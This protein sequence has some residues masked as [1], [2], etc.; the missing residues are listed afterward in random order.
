MKNI[1]GQNNCFF[2]P[3]NSRPSNVSGDYTQLPDPWSQFIVKYS[4]FSENSDQDSSPR[5]PAD[6]I[7]VSSMPNAVN[8]E[9]EKYALLI[10]M[11]IYYILVV[12]EILIF[13]IILIIS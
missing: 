10:N 4:D 1:Y 8:T 11:I 6:I 9:P 13:I 5:T 7:G 3:I 12:T 2:L